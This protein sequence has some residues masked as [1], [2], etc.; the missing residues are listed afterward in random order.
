MKKKLFKPVLCAL[1]SG[2]ILA[3]VVSHAETK[4]PA[5]ADQ[6]CVVSNTDLK[7][8]FAKRKISK[9]GLVKPADSL[10]SVFS[11]SESKDCDFY[12][13]G[14]Q[15]FLWLSSPV[16]STYVFD[17]PS[18]FDVVQKTE[19][20]KD[21]FPFKLKKNSLNK[22]NN[23]YSI[24]TLKQD[25]PFGS[26]GQAGGKGVLLSQQASLTYYGINV[27]DVFASYRTGQAQGKFKGTEIE[28]EFPNTIEGLRRVEKFA[29]RRFK[30]GHTLAMEI[31]TSWV[32]ASTVDAS[33]YLVIDA[34]V[35]NY[36][37]KVQP[38][39]PYKRVP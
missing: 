14:A 32:D 6:T 36:D 30:D 18:F 29:G 22:I 25:D 31:K 33:R 35:P 8:W 26:T 7:Q 20:D 5:D 28:Y 3:S 21:K 34:K 12:K 16:E 15:M 38:N 13:W 19:S 17:G 37:K 10:N 9:G 2:L 4:I 1:Y 27:N 24:R 23:N 11:E 39:G